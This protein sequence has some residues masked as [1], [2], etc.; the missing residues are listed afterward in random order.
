MRRTCSQD[1]AFDHEA[2]AGGSL[3]VPPQARDLE[4]DALAGGP[5]PE[6]PPLLA[7]VVTAVARGCPQEVTE[8]EEDSPHRQVPSTRVRQASHPPPRD[9]TSTPQQEQSR[10]ASRHRVS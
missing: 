8:N 2:D 9:G 1:T 10:E 4:G 3:R 5:L 6:L 7:R